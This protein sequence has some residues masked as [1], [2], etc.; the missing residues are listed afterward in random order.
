MP[1]PTVVERLRSALDATE[2]EADEH[3]HRKS[4][5]WVR[6]LVERDRALL[7]AYERADRYV[8]EHVEQCGESLCSCREYVT[9][10]ATSGALRMV[11]ERAAEFWLGD[12]R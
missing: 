1:D 11:V 7:T 12:N 5:R 6:R 4:A 8:A 3:V 9:W 10:T 2:R